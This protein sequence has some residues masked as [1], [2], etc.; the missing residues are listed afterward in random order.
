MGGRLKVW[1]LLGTLPVVTALLSGSVVLTGTTT[2]AAATEYYPVPADR[3]YQL[4]GHGYGHGHGLSQWGAQ[5]AALSGLSAGEILAFYYPG[6]THTAIGNPLLTVQLTASASGDVRVDSSPGLPMQVTDATTGLSRSGPVA[7]YRVITTGATQSVLYFDGVNWAPFSLGGSGAYSG[8]IRFTTIDGVTVFSSSGVARNYRGEVDVKRTA[9]GVS[10]AVN[11]VHMEDYLRGVVPRE[12]PSWFEPTALAAQS[13]AARSYAWWDVNSPSSQPWDLC[14]TTACQV[15]GG[16]L[17]YDPAKGWVSQEPASTN[18][19]IAS[20]AGLALYYA[21]R[22]AFTQFSASSGGWISEGGQP[23][24]APHVDPYDGMPSQ[25]TNYKWAATLSAATIEARYPSIGTL[26]AVEV[27]ARDGG[28]EWGGRITSLRLIGTATSQTVSNARFD[29]KSEW[30][31]PRVS[32]NPIGDVNRMDPAAGSTVRIQGWAIDPDT[33]G[34]I[35]VHVYVDDAGVANVRADVPRADV[36]AAYPDKGNAHGFDVT[37]NTGYGAHTI[38]VYAINVGPGE[39]N[40]RLACQVVAAGHPPTGT[41]EAV[42]VVNGAAR[43]QG[44][45]FDPDTAA[46]IDVHVYVN[47]GGAGRAVANQSRPDVGAAHPSAG[48][49][50]GFDVTVPIPEGSSQVCAYAINVLGGASNTVLGCRTVT[51]AVNPI[52][53]VERVTGSGSA[54]TVSGWA[55]DPETSAPIDV[56]VYV[57]G[58]PVGRAVADGDR[59]DVGRAHPAAGSR[60]GFEFSAQVSPGTRNVC[61]FAINV[62]QGSTNPQLGCRS[63]VVGVPPIGNL[64]AV[65]VRGFMARVSGW[66]LDP[67]TADPIATH[68]YVDGRFAISAVADGDRADVGRVHP[69]TGARHGLDVQVPITGGRHSVCVFAIN[70]AGGSTNPLLGCRTVD[71]SPWVNNPRG[72]LEGSTGARGTIALSGWTIDPDVPTSPVPVHVYVDG[73]GAGALTASGTRADVAA[74]FPGA[75][76]GHGYSGSVPATPGRHQVCLYAIN[77]GPGDSNPLLGCATTLVG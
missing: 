44:W 47:G 60:H 66:A 4:D 18:A 42:T 64:E 8:P 31:K 41:V 76:P 70:V 11:V 27:V 9:S 62:G 45:T 21:G 57:D 39:G 74:V 26:R 65:T 19:A 28:G 61:V 10:T 16:R 40:P 32:A 14:D 59:A 49:D 37:V 34:P 29:L 72:N 73:R 20:T 22:P 77:Q 36:G 5:G 50:H 51:L 75:G 46:P 12:S 6:T 35:D 23:Y 63:V 30:W 48:P 2:A 17:L 55:L 53:N 24:L 58:A 15:Y 52:G 13:V 33:A 38:C 68:V 3:V 43:V 67:D 56:H 1:S 69:A 25:N 7:A 71:L 54:I